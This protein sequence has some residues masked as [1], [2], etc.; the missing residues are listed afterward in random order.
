VLISEGSAQRRSSECTCQRL[1]S[2]LVS[3]SSW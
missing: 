1:R 2:I 3:L